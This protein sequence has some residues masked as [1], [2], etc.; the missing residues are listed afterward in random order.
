[1]MLPFLCL[2]CCYSIQQNVSL[3]AGG[4]AVLRTFLRVLPAGYQDTALTTL[5]IAIR[6]QQGYIVQ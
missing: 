3:T 6:S 1:M 2:D 5:T 4:A